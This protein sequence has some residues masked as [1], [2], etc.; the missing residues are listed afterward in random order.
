VE[1]AALFEVR[2]LV[3]QYHG[4][5]V[6]NHMSFSIQ[7]GEMLGFI[8]S[9]GAGKSTTIR[10]IMGIETQA[11][12]EILWEGKNLSCVQLKKY[13]GYVPQ[14]IAIYGN[15]SAYENVRFFCSLYGYKGED[16]KNRTKQALEFV[17]LWEHRKGKTSEVFRRHAEKI[18]YCLRNCSSTASFDYG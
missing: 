10:M 8:G 9:N 14:E 2:D 16:L 13:L 15:L 12:G 18:E 3:K 17:H 4:K 5:N 11:K 7:Q 6:V 1:N